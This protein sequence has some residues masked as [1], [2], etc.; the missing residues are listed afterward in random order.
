M[1]IALIAV[2]SQKQWP[3]DGA[4]KSPFIH[5]GEIPVPV[6]VSGKVSTS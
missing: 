5:L 2:Y 4:F 1:S 6:K 3:A